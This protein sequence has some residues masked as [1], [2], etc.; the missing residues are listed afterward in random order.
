M[1]NI[2]P[3]NVGSITAPSLMFG[4]FVRVAVASARTLATIMSTTPDVIQ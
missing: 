1:T 2:Q 4:L 3:A